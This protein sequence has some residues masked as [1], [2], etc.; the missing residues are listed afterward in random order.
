[1]R[2]SEEML[3]KL[4]V[5]LSSDTKA[6]ELNPELIEREQT[7]RDALKFAMSYTV[8]QKCSE[9]NKCGGDGSVE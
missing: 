4:L 9:V 7:T 8:Q 1:M 6:A 2:G 5:S 3:I